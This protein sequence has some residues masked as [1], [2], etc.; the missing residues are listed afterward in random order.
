MY[1]CKLVMYY[2]SN[3]LYEHRIYNIL[4]KSKKNIYIIC[5]LALFLRFFSL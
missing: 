4:Y 2:M 3:V 5:I 1:V